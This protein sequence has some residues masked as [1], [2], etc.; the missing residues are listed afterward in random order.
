MSAAP[1]SREC[2]RFDRWICAYVDEELDAVHCLEVEDHLVACADCS[3]LVTTLRT[4]RI[5]LRAVCAVKAPTSLREKVARSLQAEARPENRAPMPRKS[6][7]DDDTTP[8]ELDTAASVRP[9]APPLA[10]LRFVVPLA[11]AATLALVFGAMR[12]QQAEDGP[13]E[14]AAAEAGV[15]P[16]YAAATLEG[17][18]EDLVAQHA[19]PPPPETTDPEGLRRFDPFIGV[20]V[21]TPQFDSIDATYVGARMHQRAALLQYVVRSQHRVT[22]YVFDP[23]RVPVRPRALE[24]R[25]F[26]HRNVYVGHIRGYSVAASEQNG[27]GYALASDLSDDEAAKLVLMAA[28]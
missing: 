27:V 16:I 20:R 3:E 28:R 7:Q 26:G 10:R 1:K 4:T 15:D 23:R 12:L 8:S 13:K 5:S 22:M 19:H 11:A 25:Q 21:K 18:L 24:E 2:E 9:P 14:K 17:L 6:K